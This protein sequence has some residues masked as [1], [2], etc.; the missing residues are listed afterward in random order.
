VNLKKIVH[1]G[2]G[3]DYMDQFV[4]I[5]RRA[6]VIGIGAVEALVV[7]CGGTTD[8]VLSA[9][10]VTLPG[11]TAAQA[12][13]P[14]Q[15]STP[16]AAVVPT[17]EPTA[18]SLPPTEKPQPTDEPSSTPEIIVTYANDAERAVAEEL[19]VRW[20]WETNFAERTIQLTELMTIL[21]RDQIIP[22]DIPTFLPVANAPDYMKPREPVVSIVIDGDARAYPLAM[23]MWHEIVNDTIGG[24]PVTVTFC[25]LCN[26]SITFERM[27][28]GQELTFGTSGML[29]RSDLV[30]WD[31]QSQSLWQQITCNAIVGDFAANKTVLKQLPSAIIAWETF[32]E[33]YP[34]GKVLRRV[35]N[36]TGQAIRQYDNPPYAGYDNVDSQPF[37]FLDPVDDRL[38]AT[39]RVLTIDGEMPVAYP[40]SFLEETPVLND[41][42]DGEDI[43]AFF[44]NGTFSAFLNRAFADQSVGSVTVFSRNVGDQTLT[45]ELSDTGITDVETGSDWNLMGMAIDRELEGT[46]LEPVIHANHFWFAWAVSKPDTQ[47]RDSLDDLSG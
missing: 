27:V 4:R 33:S 35:T 47:I 3:L 21:G 5:G 31:R 39:S 42:I 17:S 28:D 32:A 44:E 14:P 12:S 45:F 46:Q 38:A 10:T 9:P 13:P 19:K 20:G 25:P 30:M 23:L 7:A 8:E 36:S 26:T 37:L 2:F 18:T 34:E 43:V 40:F 15:T 6:S 41:S 11:T 29:R 24:V 16:I 22:I 1:G